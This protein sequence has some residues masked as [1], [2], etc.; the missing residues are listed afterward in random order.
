MAAKTVA[1]HFKDK[2]GTLS[3]GSVECSGTTEGGSYKK[4]GWQGFISETIVAKEIK[5]DEEELEGVEI[6]CPSCEGMLMFGG[7]PIASVVVLK[8]R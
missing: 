8:N 7:I 1:E 6:Q 2:P 4:C 3:D 5:N